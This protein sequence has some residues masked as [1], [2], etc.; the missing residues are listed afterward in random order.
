MTVETST[1]DLIPEGLQG[2]D[3]RPSETFL[4]AEED[5][6]LR[7]STEHGTPSEDS[8]PAQ[9]RSITGLKV[10]KFF[11]P[12]RH[13]SNETSPAD[14]ISLLEKLVV[15]CLRVSVIYCFSLRP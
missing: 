11:V 7:E 6:V 1:P 9:Q 4:P 15:F 13:T 10:C 5:K 12:R 8:A 3:G 2:E 14:H